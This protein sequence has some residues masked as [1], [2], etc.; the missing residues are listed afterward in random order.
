MSE[1]PLAA[2]LLSAPTAR[3]SERAQAVLYL[4]VCLACSGAGM[5]ALKYAQLR[6]RRDLLALGYVLEAIAFGV[7]PLCL[8]ALPLRVVA[9]CW[10]ASSNVIAF[11][12]GVVLFDDSLSVRALL[13]CACNVLGVVLVA[14]AA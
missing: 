6:T 2:P 4:A 10:A 14:S 5:I 8:T 1:H 11:A 7:Y 9:V 3:R 12:S 13:G